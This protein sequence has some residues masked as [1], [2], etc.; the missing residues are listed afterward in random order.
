MLPICD[1][2]IATIKLGPLE[3]TRADLDE[4]SKDTIRDAYMR[5]RAPQDGLIA[6]A[7]LALATDGAKW[8]EFARGTSYVEHGEK[9]RA[10]LIAMGAP[11][12]IALRLGKMAIERWAREPSVDDA[13]VEEMCDFFGV[14]LAPDG[15]DDC[16]SPTGT[17]E[18]HSEG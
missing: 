5:T 10:W 9:V 15:S 7:A 16:D 11:I 8:P 17:P 2:K 4:F 1:P 13:V 12:K 3:L 14:V 18:T 6:L